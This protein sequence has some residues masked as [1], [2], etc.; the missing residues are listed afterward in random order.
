MP[1]RISAKDYDVVLK[2]GG[3]LA[4]RSAEDEI[5]EREAADG[6]NFLLDAELSEFQRRPPFDLVDTA[7]NAGS[8][9][10][11]G[12]FVDSSGNVFSFF[13]AGN[14]VYE[15]DGTSLLSTTLD[16]VSATAEL[17][18]HWRSHSWELDDQVI[19][20]DLNLLE[21]V[22]T[23][24]G[25]TWQDVTF[26]DESGAG[27]GNF[28]S[29]YCRVSRERAWFGH[30]KAGATTTPHMVV[31][32]AVEA[33]TQIS[34]ANKPSSAIGTAD[35][36]YILTPDLKPINGMVGAL[37]ALLLSTEQG[38]LFHL[39]GDNSQDFSIKDFYKGSGVVGEEAIDF[40][41]NDVFYGRQGRV[42]SLTDTDRFGDTEA[43]DITK[44]IADQL[45][46][47]TGW[48]IVYNGRLNR[49]YLFP[50]GAS[51]VW[52]FQTALR[53]TDRSPWMRWKTNHAL[54]FQ[55]TFVQSMLDP[56]DGL[57]YVFMGDSSGNIY[58]LEGTGLAG[59]A[60]TTDISA[61]VTSKLFSIPETAKGYDFEGYIKYRR[62]LAS[63]ISV[64]MLYSGEEVFDSALVLEVPS[65]ISAT[66]Y[67]GSVYYND[68]EYYGTEFA[69]R[70]ERKRIEPRGGSNEF[71]IQVR[72]DGVNA[73]NINEVGLRFKGTSN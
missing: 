8:I 68:D 25:T 27:F 56:G 3:G 71:Q 53:G 22:K 63:T 40:V 51:E 32:S 72:V 6:Q 54:A 70:L 24:D 57:E 52:V 9:L 29:K 59:D 55:P 58:R 37:G 61:F 16:T 30:V 31:G 47:Y 4:T 18:G 42:E 64:T 10:G 65:H 49:V 20:T 11:G 12:S 35:P 33:L 67:A 38:E 36:F 5:N 50:D 41:G 60:G 2:F 17:R 34:N 15:F 73:F 45:A 46:T 66:F 7:A 44:G 69:G 62:G 19:I 23:W 26:T 39:T 48:K 43:D 13:Q 21:V 1:P 14:T 28:Y